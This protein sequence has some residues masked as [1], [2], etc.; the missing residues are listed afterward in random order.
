MDLEATAENMEVK[1]LPTPGLRDDLNAIYIHG[2]RVIFIQ[3][4]LGPYT[5]RSART[6]ELGH[7][8]HKDEHSCSIRL[9]R[10][11]DEWA[12][13]ALI[14]PHDSREAEQ[15]YGHRTGVIAW[16]LGVTPHLVKVW[17]TMARTAPRKIT[18]RN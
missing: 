13:G 15:L 9:E 14:T 5:A 10:R 3:E 17:R 2:H 6:H 11:A 16:A 4:N 7:A 8:H 18:V 12:A 1:I